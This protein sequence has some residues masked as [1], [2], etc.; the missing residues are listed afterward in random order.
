[1]LYSIYPNPT[2]QTFNIKAVNGDQI[3]DV[4]IYDLFGQLVYSKKAHQIKD[5]I[6][7]NHLTKG[8]YLVNIQSINSAN[9]SNLSFNKLI[10]K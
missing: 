5:I 7:I 1:M 3:V 4:L 6:T 10:V 2:N 8:I 9:T